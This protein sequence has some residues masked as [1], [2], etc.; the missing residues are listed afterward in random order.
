MTMPLSRRR[1]RVAFV[2]AVVAGVLG[3]WPAQPLPIAL[4]A[5][6]D[7]AFA[8]VSDVAEPRD[9]RADLTPVVGRAT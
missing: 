5:S 2:F 9:P 1:L 6:F 8:R 3:A 4:L 7:D